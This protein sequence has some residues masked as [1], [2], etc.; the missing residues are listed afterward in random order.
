MR[1]KLYDVCIL[2]IVSY[3]F[4]KEYKIKKLLLSTEDFIP[5]YIHSPFF[6][7]SMSNISADCIIH[8]AYAIVLCF[9]YVFS[10]F[11]VLNYITCYFLSV[12]LIQGS[13]CVH[14][15]RVVFLECTCLFFNAYTYSI[16]SSRRFL[17]IYH[18]DPYEY[19]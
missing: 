16:G 3:I 2:L 9:L 7:C 4:I 19:F 13:F 6:Y 15:N 5:W 18:K 12:D 1:K 10:L 14:K 8:L 11:I 17:K